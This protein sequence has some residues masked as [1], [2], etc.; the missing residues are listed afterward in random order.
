MQHANVMI[1]LI[2][3]EYS[4]E[5]YEDIKNRQSDS[6]ILLSDQGFKL[7]SSNEFHV[8]IISVTYS[9]FNVF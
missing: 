5:S 3:N 1:I 6:Y 4:R 9:H 7:Y 8:A 2:L